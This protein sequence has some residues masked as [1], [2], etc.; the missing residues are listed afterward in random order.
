MDDDWQVVFKGEPNVVGEP[1]L[2]D[3]SRLVGL[4]PKM[5]EPCLSDGAHARVPE[6]FLDVRHMRALVQIPGVQ[7][8]TEP[9]VIERRLNRL[10]CRA[11]GD[12]RNERSI[13]VPARR[14][15]PLG[16]SVGVNVGV[17]DS[18]SGLGLE[19]GEGRD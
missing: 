4:V 14:G 5:I 12:A 13:F 15:D 7:R 11:W 10:R 8:C 1:A 18:H 2:G 16:E 17:E 6:E 9:I 3:V 19:T